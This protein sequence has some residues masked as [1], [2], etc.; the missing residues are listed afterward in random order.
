LLAAL[1]LCRISGVVVL[2]FTQAA[3]ARAARRVV[4]RSMGVNLCITVFS[5]RA[6]RE[7]SKAVTQSGVAQHRP[8]I[9]AL[10]PSCLPSSVLSSMQDTGEVSRGLVRKLPGFYNDGKRRWSCPPT[11]NHQSSG[12]RH[13]IDR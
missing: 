6:R 1:E 10:S 3:L 11:A 9:A 13:R 2:R 4:I 8:N 7:R 12:L 5:E